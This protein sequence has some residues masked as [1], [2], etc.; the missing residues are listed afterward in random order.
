MFKSKRIVVSACMFLSFFFLPF[1][2]WYVPF[3]IGIIYSWYTTYYEFI[4]LGF[5]MDLSYASGYFVFFSNY[6]IPLFFTCL[7]TLLILVLQSVKNRVRFY[8]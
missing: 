4:F 2:P 6:H 7:T 1:L 3:I 8:S 5:L